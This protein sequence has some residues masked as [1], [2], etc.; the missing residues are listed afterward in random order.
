M[1]L[2]VHLLGQPDGAHGFDL[3]LWALGGM[4]LQSLLF[5]LAHR[6]AGLMA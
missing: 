6:P 4:P 5:L 2:L 1:L 3:L